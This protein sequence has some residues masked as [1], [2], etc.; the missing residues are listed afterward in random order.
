MS[1]YYYAKPLK[2]MFLTQP[3]DDTPTLRMAGADL[4]LVVALTIPVLVLG[5]FGWDTVT[6]ATRD[7]VAMVR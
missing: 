6:E 5:L 2:A 7:A 4:A 3:D 1:L